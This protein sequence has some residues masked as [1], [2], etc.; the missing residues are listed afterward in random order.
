MVETIERHTTARICGTRPR[1]VRVVLQYRTDDPY[2]V[3]L[4]F[5]GPA[6]LTETLVVEDGGAVEDGPRWTVGRDLLAEGRYG[7]A[8][9]GDLRVRPDED[10]G[11]LLEWRC[12]GGGADVRLGTAEL[13]AFLDRTYRAVPAGCESAFVDWPHTPEEFLRRI[14]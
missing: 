11:V 4:C 14:V 7:C 10:G 2:A 3:A 5:P 13:G 6:R 1:R 8:G 12:P 9:A